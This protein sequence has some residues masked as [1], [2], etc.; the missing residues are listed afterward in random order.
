MQTGRLI[1]AIVL[2][3]LVPLLV[4]H[5][6][7]RGE[8]ADLDSLAYLHWYWHVGK[9]TSEQFFSELD[10]S[11]WYLTLVQ[12]HVFEWGFSLWG[13]TLAKLGASEAMFLGATAALSLGLKVRPLLRYCPSP[14]LGLAWYVSWYYILMEMN[15]IRAGVAAGFLLA[16]I[17]AMIERRWWR[18]L[19]YVFLA[20]S[21][22]LSALVGLLFPMLAWKKLGRKAL[23]A[24]LVISFPLGY[25]EL[26]TV[27]GFL[28]P[29]LP[30]VEEYKTLLTVLGSYSDLNRYNTISLTRVALALVLIWKLPEL[31]RSMAL[32]IGIRAYVIS[33]AL[34]YALASFPI[35]G[36]RLSQL[37]GV[38][39]ILAVPAIATML[40]PRWFWLP[41]YLA[42]CVVQFYALALHFRLADFFYFVGEPRV[43]NP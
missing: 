42:I 14:A 22:H 19:L 4:V 6:A 23:L 9:L 16:A 15:A 2:C 40:K 1:N 41:L 17:A 7:F 29:W 8:T 30:K 13:W 24:V 28:E 43:V 38:L 33:Q 11:S 5:L 12:P 26:V 37:V 10:G 35:F 39:D 3:T 27:F 31:G 32:A 34:Y 21:F 20:C 25:I 36:S 18:Y